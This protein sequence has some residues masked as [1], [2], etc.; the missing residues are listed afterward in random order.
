MQSHPDQLSLVT[1]QVIKGDINQAN[2]NVVVNAANAELRPGGGVDGAIHRAAGPAL[3]KAV[4][5]YAPLQPGQAVLTPGFLLKAKHVIHAVGPIWDETDDPEHLK[6]L[7]MKTYQAI[8]AL[9]IREGFSSVAIPNIA[10]GVYRFPKALAA[11]LV[12]EVTQAYLQR[13]KTPLS[14]FFYCFD[15]INFQL[16]QSLFNKK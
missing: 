14:I 4:I 13:V 11:K 7:L 10:T 1:I 16:Y 3:A 6:N 8:Y 9:V 12:F 15:D 2:V 5:Q